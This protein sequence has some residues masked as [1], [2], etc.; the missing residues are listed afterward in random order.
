MIEKI[1][2]KYGDFPTDAERE[3]AVVE[4]Q[5][6]L[7]HPAW[8]FV[9][10]VMAENLKIV[11]NNIFDLSTPEEERKTLI[12]ARDY[13]KKMMNLPQA[14]IERFNPSTSEGL[15]SSGDPYH[16]KPEELRDAQTPPPP[17]S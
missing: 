14:Q 10:G 1:D 7:N 15:A 2:F 17:S 9:Y 3:A 12:R 5:T 8:K 11:E 13:L 4:L 6:L 16:T